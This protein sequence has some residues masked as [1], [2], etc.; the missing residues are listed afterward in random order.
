MELNLTFIL[1]GI[2]VLVSWAAWQKPEMMHQLI[3]QPYA[4]QRDN[5]WYRFLT[6]GFLHAD[7]SHLFFN[8]FT[9][10]FFGTNVEYTFT[11]IFG[12]IPGELCYLLVYLGGI[13][14]SDIPTFLKHRNDPPYRALGASGGVASVLFASILFYPITPVCLFAALCVPGFIFGVLYMM[15]SYFS[16]RRMAGN[17]NHDAHFYGALYG[18][19][20]SLALVPQTLP[21]FFEQISQWRLF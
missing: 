20:L 5:S 1:I 11:G 14:V 8:M 4:V 19:V 13:I 10:Y 9:L 12:L 15:Y 7:F 3:F 16:G 18:F 6:S 21:N 17:I 2:T